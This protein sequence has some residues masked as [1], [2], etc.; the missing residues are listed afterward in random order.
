M[1]GGKETGAQFGGLVSYLYDGRLRCA[2]GR[3][4]PL[5]GTV[6][7][8]S[9]TKEEVINAFA[10]IR[11][12]RNDIA[13]PVI[14]IWMSCAEGESLDIAAWLWIGSRL[15]EEFG[16][17][18]AWIAVGHGDTKFAHVHY[19]LSRIRWNGTT[20]REKLRDYEIVERIAAEAEVRFGLKVTS[21][22]TRSP[23]PH[24]RAPH[25]KQASGRERNM[26]RR[27]RIPLK[28][29][30]RQ[31]ILDCQA[32][33]Y[34]GYRLLQAIQQ[35]GWDP[36]VKWRRGGIV[37]GLVWTDQKTGKHIP[38]GRL[39]LGGGAAWLRSI[40]GIPGMHHGP[41]LAQN[42]APRPYRP[43]VLALRSRPNPGVAGGCG[44]WSRAMS[45][46]WQATANAVESLLAPQVLTFHSASPAIPPQG[47]TGIQQEITPMSPRR[48]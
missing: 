15:A 35:R 7:G 25:R 19:A 29:Q 30:L 21:R 40:G 42:W 4:T 33:G 1:I 16:G 9:G 27:G 10:A 22:P 17:L 12:M 14:H 34:R 46:M 48:R 26:P 36:C 3:G 24:G 28:D 20:N 32:E 18:D 11:E 43:N 5:G 8:E 13:K 31:V 39:G 45:W 23:G 6:L 44:W 47:P 37:S 2:E 38:M 41:G